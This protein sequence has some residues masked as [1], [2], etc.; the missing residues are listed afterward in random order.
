MHFD[1]RLVVLA[2]YLLCA[3]VQEAMLTGESVP[4]SKNLRAVAEASG[5]GDRKCMAFSAT[6]V[7]AGQG[8]GVITATGTWRMRGQA[9][10]VFQI[11][12]SDGLEAPFCL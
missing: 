5:L 4:I 11:Q 9:V 1:H 6:T 7:S 12:V 3:Q 2:M 10:L 8:L